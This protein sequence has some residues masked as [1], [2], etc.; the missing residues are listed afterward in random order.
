MVSPPAPTS[1]S[2]P[3]ASCRVETPLEPDQLQLVGLVGQLGARVVVGDRAPGEALAL[4]DDL[5]HPGLEL[6]EVL[7]HERGR[8]VEVVVEAVVDRGADPEPRLR[9]HLL[10]RLRQNVRGGVPQDVVA[11]VGVDRD[12]LDHVAVGQLLGEVA[13]RAR[14]AGRGDPGRDHVG[15]VGEELPRP[16]AGRDRALGR[17]G[18][19]GHGDGHVGHRVAPVAGAGS[20]R[21]ML[22]ARTPPAVPDIGWPSR[23]DSGAPVALL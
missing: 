17:T 15:L 19:A 21:S 4:L 1:A 2:A 14:A 8:D 10:D 16:G 6:L 13:Q 3:S 23:C 18:G 7:G 22:A 20:C 9:E 11:V 5:A 12:R